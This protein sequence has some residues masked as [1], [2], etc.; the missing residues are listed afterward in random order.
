MNSLSIYYLW[1]LSS[2]FRSDKQS[3]NKKGRLYQSKYA[4]KTQKDNILCH[5]IIVSDFDDNLWVSDSTA[6]NTGKN[7]YS[8]HFGV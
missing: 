5:A 1:H 7:V 8:R 6:I 4:C 2:H 3:R